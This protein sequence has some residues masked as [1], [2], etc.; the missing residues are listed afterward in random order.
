M[1]ALDDD[2]RHS[3]A[4]LA[5]CDALEQRDDAKARESLKR[6]RYQAHAVLSR[7]KDAPALPGCACPE[8]GPCDC[9]DTCVCAGE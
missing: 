3:F 7:Y 4:I 1:A 9:E 8:L 6:A 2:Q 5:I